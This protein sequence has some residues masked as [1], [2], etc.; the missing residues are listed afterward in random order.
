MTI[1]EVKEMTHATPFVP[2]E[3][4]TADGRRVPVKHPDFIAM[5]PT[6]RILTV[7]SGPRDASIFINVPVITALKTQNPNPKRKRSA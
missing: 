2:F 6:G 1:E 5:S 7:F 4:H 3:I